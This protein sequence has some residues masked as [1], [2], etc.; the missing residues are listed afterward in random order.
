MCIS[1]VV[2]V[3]NTSVTCAV[4]L[5]GVL[6]QDTAHMLIKPRVDDVR[7]CLYVTV[8]VCVRECVCFS[9]LV[10]VRTT[11]LKENNIINT[12]TTTYYLM[13]I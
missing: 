2:N 3:I 5:G 7:A 12:A 9:E 6:P 1:A 4:A 13:E 10:T 8:L 11:K